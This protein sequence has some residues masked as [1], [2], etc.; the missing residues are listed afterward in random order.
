MRRLSD[1]EKILVRLR[2]LTERE[3]LLVVLHAQATY[4]S[5]GTGPPRYRGMVTGVRVMGA[6]PH[7]GRGHD[8]GGICNSLEELAEALTRVLVV[9]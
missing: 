4:G 7:L 5:G 3:R 6:L 1:R 2:P 9:G 8:T